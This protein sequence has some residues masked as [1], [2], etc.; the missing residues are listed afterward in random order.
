MIPPPD[1]E[2]RLRDISQPAPPPD[3]LGEADPEKT[4]RLAIGGAVNE[5]VKVIESGDKI[6]KGV[7]GWGEVANTLA[8]YAAL[9]LHWLRVFLGG[10]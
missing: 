10:G 1:T 3:P 2:A 8:P 5:L 6:V 4:R 9:I 7:K